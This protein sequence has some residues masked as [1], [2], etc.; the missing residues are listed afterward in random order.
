M[1]HGRVF[2]I[3]EQQIEEMGV[4]G[5]SRVIKAQVP[6]AEMF[7]YATALRTLSQGRGIFSLEFYCYDTVPEKITAEIIARIEGRIPMR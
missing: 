4:S 2:W 3:I 7:G 5:S 1:P 6:L